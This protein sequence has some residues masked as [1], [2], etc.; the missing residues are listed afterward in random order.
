MMAEDA[1]MFVV[2]LLMGA[3]AGKRQTRQEGE[4]AVLAA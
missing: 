3:E 2:V 4:L 1:V